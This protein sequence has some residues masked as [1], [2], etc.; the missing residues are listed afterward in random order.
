MAISIITSGHPDLTP[1]PPQCGK[2]KETDMFA[3]VMNKIDR[4]AMAFVVVLAASPILSIAA[5][6]AFV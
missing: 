2:P 3:Q 4:F 1:T 6:A 5:Q